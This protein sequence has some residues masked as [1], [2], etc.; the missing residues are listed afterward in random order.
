MFEAPGVLFWIETLQT[1]C[2]PSWCGEESLEKVFH[3]FNLT[4]ICNIGSMT[5]SEKVLHYTLITHF[6][7]T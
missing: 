7:Q 1:E 2:F 4:L 3:K 6:K 5:S